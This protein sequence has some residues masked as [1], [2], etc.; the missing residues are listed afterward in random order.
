MGCL[1]IGTYIA[2]RPWASLPW[3]IGTMGSSSPA[4]GGVIACGAIIS[5]GQV[6]TIRKYTLDVDCSSSLY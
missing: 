3:G 1:P 4:S 6:L 5:V 2:A